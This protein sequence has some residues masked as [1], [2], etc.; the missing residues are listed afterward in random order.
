MV[1]QCPASFQPT[2]ASAARMRGFFR[3]VERAGLRFV[4]EPRGAWP[5]A[6]VAELCNEL[7]LIHCVDPFLGEPVAGDVAYF[8]LHGIGGYSYRYTDA[9]VEKLS[10]LMPAQARLRPLQ[11]Q[12]YAGGCRALPAT[13]GLVNQRLASLTGQLHAQQNGDR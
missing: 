6:L 7:W 12:V 1:F 9:D 10:Y 5:K 8:R 3:Q 2:E 4:W 13:R 11:Q